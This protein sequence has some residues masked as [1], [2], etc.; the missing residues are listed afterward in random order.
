VGDRQFNLLDLVISSLERIGQAPSGLLVKVSGAFGLARADSLRDLLVCMRPA[1][2][3]RLGYRQLWSSIL[4]E[5]STDPQKYYPASPASAWLGIG[6]GRC[7]SS[8]AII[9]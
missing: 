3:P 6:L 2:G 4:R 5:I 8:V 1:E 7:C 9:F